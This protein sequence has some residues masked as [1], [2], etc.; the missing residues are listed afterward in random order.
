MK[1]FSTLKSLT[2]AI[3]AA[4]VLVGCGGS[5]PAPQ[6]QAGCN[7]AGPNTPMWV[8]MPEVE[9][10]IAAVG[11]AEKSPAGISFQRQEAMANARDELARELGVQVKNMFK[12]FTQT[13]G[14]GNAQT[15]DKVAANVS[16][17]VAKQTLNGSKLKN[18]WTSPNGTLFVMVAIAKNTVKQSVKQSAVSSLKNDKALWQQFQAKKANDELDAAIDK[19]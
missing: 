9:G 8:C 14:V 5:Q 12:N 15:V 1:E 7:I 16:K 10:A 4:A 18:M 3:A 2:V 11:S 19:M 17:Q 6:Q 13:T